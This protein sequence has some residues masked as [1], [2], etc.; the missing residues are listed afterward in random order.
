MSVP[1]QYPSD[2]SP[3][4]LEATFEIRQVLKTLAKRAEKITVQGTGE[5]FV[6]VILEVSERGEVIVDAS[7]SPSVN[8]SAMGA[9]GVA[10]HAVLDRVDI[11]L[12]LSKGKLINYEGNVAL[13]FAAPLRLHKLQR[14]EFSR[15]PTPMAKPL[16][17]SIWLGEMAEG[18]SLVEHQAQILDISLGGLCLQQ[19]PQLEMMAEVI[20]KNCT[21]D[22]PEGGI[23]FDLFVRHNFDVE[24]RVGKT[25][26]RAG[27][28]FLNLSVAGRQLVQKFMGKLER[29]RR[30]ALA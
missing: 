22:L 21:M 24:N 25:S 2:L 20:Y 28:E 29:D 4:W 5:P 30:S 10:V 17:C 9:E 16:M 27:C 1:R 23:R 8:T 18:A 15:L 3:Y 12:S 7:A 14:R 19:P 26:R 11:D 13:Q 6:T